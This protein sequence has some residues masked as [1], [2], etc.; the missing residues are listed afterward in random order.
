MSYGH[1]TLFQSIYQNFTNLWLIK[2]DNQF[3]QGI[4]NVGVHDLRQ[5][6]EAT[7]QNVHG[8]QFHFFYDNDTYRH[9]SN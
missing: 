3:V 1:D 7:N 5:L 4:A 2:S 8:I 6:D 9:Q